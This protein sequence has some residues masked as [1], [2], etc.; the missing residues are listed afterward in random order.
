MADFPTALSAVTDNVDDAMAKFIN[1]LE[2]K[3]GI[4][5]SAVNTSL[6]YLLKN[7]SS[8]NP[9]HKHTVANGATDIVGA[10]TAWTPTLAD[11]FTKGDGTLNCAYIQIG[12]LVICRFLFTLG[13]TS[14]IGVNCTLSLPVTS[15]TYS[16]SA[17]LGQCV[18]SDTGTFP[19]TGFFDW[20]STE[21]VTV[22]TPYL[23]GTTWQVKSSIGVSNPF[24]W[25]PTDY[26]DGEF[27]YEA[28]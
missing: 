8:S 25:A 22:R 20:Y 18:L 23:Y 28:A 21:K 11:G 1:N 17:G 10:W 24:T 12:K 13:S 15:I 14:A 2:A 3:V 5:S 26:I 27:M 16:S 19:Y 4:N 9:G 7:T 6:D